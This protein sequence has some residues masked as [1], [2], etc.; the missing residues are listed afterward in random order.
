LKARLAL[1]RTASPLFDTAAT[2]SALERLY[3]AMVERRRAGLPPDH[4]G[5]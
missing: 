4:L 2:A 5:A 1:A 3:G